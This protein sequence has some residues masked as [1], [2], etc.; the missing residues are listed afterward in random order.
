MISQEKMGG[1]I[2]NWDHL[3]HVSLPDLKTMGDLKAPNV[4]SG[5]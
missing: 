2:Q 3:L 5:Q 4:I 1:C